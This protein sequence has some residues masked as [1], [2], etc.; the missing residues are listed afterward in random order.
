MII[1]VDLLNKK[2]GNLIANT[3]NMTIT[4]I[5]KLNKQFILSFYTIKKR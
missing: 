5:H 4:F 1:I 2:I 3:N